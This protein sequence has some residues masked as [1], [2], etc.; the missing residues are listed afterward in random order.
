MNVL[1]R[2]RV[3]A[4]IFLGAPAEEASGAQAPEEESKDSEAASA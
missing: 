2:Q 3:I 1:L 4:D